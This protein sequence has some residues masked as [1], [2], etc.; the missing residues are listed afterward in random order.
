MYYFRI[1]GSIELTRSCLVPEN[2]SKSPFFHYVCD[3]YD[4]GFF[5]GGVVSLINQLKSIFRY[6][7]RGTMGVW[8]S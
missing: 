8:L 2:L 6:L 5:D 1:N 7:F 3:N 4:S